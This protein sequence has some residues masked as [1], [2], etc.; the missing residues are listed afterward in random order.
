MTKSI[1]LVAFIALSGSTFAQENATKVKKFKLNSIGIDFGYTGDRYSKMNL[2]SMYDLTKN[3]SLL[4]RDLNGYTSSLYRSSDGGRI[5]I[6]ASF[7][8]FS[9]ANDSYNTNHEVRFGAYYSSR[10]PLISYN[11]IDADG[12]RNSIIYCNM[13]QEL[14]LT[15][16]YLIRKSPAKAKWFSVYAGLGASLGSSFNDKMVVMESHYDPNDYSTITNENAF[17]EAKS[18]FYSRVYAPIGLDVTIFNRVRLGL[19]GTIGVGMQNVYG[20]KTYVMPL[21]G[22][23]TTKLA[24]VF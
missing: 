7:T 23:I 8:P 1:I 17:Y 24:F 5:G 3:P 15:G 16:A 4:D 9:T 18:S 6:N 10:E 21:S 22:S 14:S 11:R 13:V 19:E 12:T 20:G 2:E